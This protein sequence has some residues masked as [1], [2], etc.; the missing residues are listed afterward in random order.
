MHRI[1]LVSPY[2]HVKSFSPHYSL[3]YI[4]FYL[5]DHGYD[6]EII[7]CSHY[8]SGLEGVIAKLMEDEKPVIG[9]TAYTRERFAAY[10]LIR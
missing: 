8:D 3:E 5:M 7:D 1:Y 4:K 9:V 10:D 2:T 6:A